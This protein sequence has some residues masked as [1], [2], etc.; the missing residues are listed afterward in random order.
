MAI[1]QITRV[2]E[3]GNE[4]EQAFFMAGVNVFFHGDVEAAIKD[5]NETQ[6]KLEAIKA[7][8]KPIKN[9]PTKAAHVCLKATR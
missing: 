7:R 3:I 2:E 5:F 6:V 8:S 1:K 4:R 9:P